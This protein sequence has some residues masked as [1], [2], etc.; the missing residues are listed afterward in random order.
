M[1]SEDLPV[2]R[3]LYGIALYK[4]EIVLSDFTAGPERRFV[5]TP[6]Q[7]MG[8]I[9]SEVT[10]RPFPGLVWMQ[11]G[12]EYEKYLLTLPPGPR[13]ILY[14]QK[15]KV[16]AKR[17]S[18]PAVAVQVGIDV[19]EKR[20]RSI[21]L[22]GFAG[23]ELRPDSILYELPLPN[24]SGSHLCLGSTERAVEGDILGA[25]AR[26]I[27]DTPFNHHNHLVGTAKIP[28]HDY[29]KQHKGRCPLRTLKRLGYGRDILG[30]D[31]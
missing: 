8:F 18:L 26:T 29:V 13:T 16:T 6:E 2:Q 22:W 30:G 9:R 10:L 23:R 15:K 28:F 12:G 4:S 7:L 20:V 31:R 5:V 21:S 17:L 11:T 3:Q 14:R 19:T 25:V 27:F 24:L 1:I